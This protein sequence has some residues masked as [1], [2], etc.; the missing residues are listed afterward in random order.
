VIGSIGVAIK[1]LVE[2]SLDAG[3]TSIT[4]RMKGYGLDLI[5]VTD[6]GQGVKATDYESLGISSN[7]AV[8]RIL[9]ELHFSQKLPYVKAQ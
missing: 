2:N 4:V 1:E 5:E 7:V 3:A 8:E 6:N 9:N